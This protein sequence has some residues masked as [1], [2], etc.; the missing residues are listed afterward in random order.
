MPRG[1]QVSRLYG[2]VRAL[3]AS[4]YGLPAA[5]LAR[6][7]HWATR[8]VYRDLHALEQAGF[9]LVRV[10]GARWKLIDGWRERVPFR[11][12]SASYWS[13]ILPAVS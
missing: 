7:N 13:F 9:P 3:A 5:E 6:R 10:E 4:K 12:R 1:N 8:T 2:L 11:S